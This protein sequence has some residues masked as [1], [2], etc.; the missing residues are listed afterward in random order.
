[1][2]RRPPRSTL[3]P[4]TTLF[5]SGELDLLH[6]LRSGR[7]G[8]KQS[9]SQKRG[10]QPTQKPPT[11]G[12]RISVS[13]ERHGLVLHLD[14]YVA[15][16]PAKGSQRNGGPG[17]ATTRTKSL[18]RVMSHSPSPRRGALLKLKRHPVGI[19]EASL[20]RLG[21]ALAH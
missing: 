15:H 7:A 2:I 11:R 19:S 3:F 6:L 8:I 21:A 18:E 12:H 4:Y 20:R 1:M 17:L 5:R 9:E 13:N 14:T 16:R 10:E